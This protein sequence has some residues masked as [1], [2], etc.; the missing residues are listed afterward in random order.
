MLFAPGFLQGFNKACGIELCIYSDNGAFGKVVTKVI[1]D[2]GGFGFACAEQ[3]GFA[4]CQLVRSLDVVTA[5]RPKACDI[6]GDDEGACFAGETGYEGDRTPMRGEV[7]AHMGVCAGNDDSV[8]V[9][10][11]H[12]RADRCNFFVCCHCVALHILFF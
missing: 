4:A 2:A 1:L 9:V 3:N 11:R 8:H 12:E 7:F 10:T 5:V 6:T